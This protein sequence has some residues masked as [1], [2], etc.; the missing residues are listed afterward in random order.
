MRGLRTKWTFDMLGLHEQGP[1]N[2][3]EAMQDAKQF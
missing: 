1:S 2:W 3:D